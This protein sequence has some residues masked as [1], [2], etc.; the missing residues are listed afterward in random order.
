MSAINWHDVVWGWGII[1]LYLAAFPRSAERHGAAIQADVW[2]RAGVALF[3]VVAIEIARFIEL[4]AAGG[5]S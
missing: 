2:V 5:A 1:A 4:S 3:G